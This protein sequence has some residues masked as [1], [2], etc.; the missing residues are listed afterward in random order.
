MNFSGYTRRNLAISIQT[1]FILPVLEAAIFEL[2]MSADVGLGP[3]RQ[4]HILVSGVIENVSAAD[5][6]SFVVVI[7]AK[8]SCFKLISKYFRFSGATLDFR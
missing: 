5:K 2:R 6:I 3:C 4:S 7:Q 1:L 8:I